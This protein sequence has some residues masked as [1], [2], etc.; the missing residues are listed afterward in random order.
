MPHWM[1]GEEEGQA[2]MIQPWV[3]GPLLR[4]LRGIL[5]L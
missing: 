2:Q 3:L 4:E 1:W 5:G